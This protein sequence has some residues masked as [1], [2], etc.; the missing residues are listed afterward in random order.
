MDTT[1]DQPQ[2]GRG[3]RGVVF[4]VSQPRAG[5]TLLQTMLGGHPQ[6]IAPGET[7]LMLPL[8]HAV[9]GSVRDVSAPYDGYLADHAISLFSQSCLSHGVSEIQREIGAAA[10]R[11][12][13]SVCARANAQFVVDKT[14]RYYWIIEDLLQ[15]LP[16]CRL[17]VLL[18]NPLAVL[19]SIAKT[20]S[21]RNLPAYRADLLEAP[22]RLANALELEHDRVMTV[23]YEKLIEDPETVLTEIQNYIGLDPVSGLSEYGSAPRRV[24]GD[25][26]GIHG[27][28]GV[29]RGSLEKW[30]RDAANDAAMW[31]VCDDYRK[32]LG[33]NLLLRLGYPPEVLEQ[34]LASVKP[35]GTA[36]APSLKSHLRPAS[37]EP[38]RSMKQIRSICAK[39]ASGG[40][41]KAA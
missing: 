32:S 13:D 24:F 38:I 12:F 16:E 26:S 37:S 40:L 4:I 29:N 21:L 27:A 10:A 41:R 25:P 28:T 1:I 33:R 36:I 31:R 18:R 17:I 8:A 6:V 34:Q 14:P 3:R 39:A 2:D 20:W 9:C 23:R 30:V 19:S 22:S 5:S 7:W 11:I 35:F 15:L